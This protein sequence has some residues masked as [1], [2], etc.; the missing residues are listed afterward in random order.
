MKNV[1]STNGQIDRMKSVY[2]EIWTSQFQS[3]WDDFSISIRLLT[4]NPNSVVKIPNFY[5]NMEWTRVMVGEP[6]WRPQREWR[7]HT[8]RV[9]WEWNWKESCCARKCY[10]F[11]VWASTTLNHS[12]MTKNIISTIKTSTQLLSSSQFHNKFV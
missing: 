9:L 11:L 5:L 3:I 6:E 2:T 7:L 10:T 4:L 12:S 8:N 1:Q